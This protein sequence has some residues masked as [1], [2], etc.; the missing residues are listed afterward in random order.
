MELHDL[1]K[2]V[3]FNSRYGNIAIS[4][5]DDG[6]TSVHWFTGDGSTHVATGRSMVH[7][8]LKAKMQQEEFAK[9]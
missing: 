7:A 5:Y 8:L 4:T 3:A 2:A 9:T 6:R 1:A